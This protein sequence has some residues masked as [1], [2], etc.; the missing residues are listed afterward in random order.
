MRELCVEKIAMSTRVALPMYTGCCSMSELRRQLLPSPPPS[1]DRTAHVRKNLFGPIDH[2]ENLKFVQD[3][4]NKISQ[5]D[6]KRWNFDFEAEKPKEGRFNWEPVSEAVPQAYEM[7]RLTALTTHATTTPH[8][9]IAAPKP[10]HKTV[11]ECSSSSKSEQQPSTSSTPVT[12]PDTP[13][14]TTTSTSI[15]T[16]KLSSPAGSSKASK[17]SPASQSIRK[18]VKL[19]RRESSRK[20]SIATPRITRKTAQPP[21]TDYLRIR[22]SKRPA[23]KLEEDPPPA[24]VKRT[25]TTSS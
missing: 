7:P 16:A 13:T 12:G 2:D 19:D 3:E 8:T 17:A 20:K 10:V 23:S 4:L 6:C 22:K 1:Q 11:P 18:A 5:A 15:T 14:P 24:L 21:V 25:K 9:T